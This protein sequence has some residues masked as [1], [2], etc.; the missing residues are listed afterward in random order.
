MHDEAAVRA[1]FRRQAGWCRNLGSP[2][3]ALVCD[4]AA[5]R[6]DRSTVLGRRILDWPAEP[7]PAVDVLTLRLAGG[8]HALARR[9]H[10]QLASCYPPSPTPDADTFWRAMQAALDNPA[11][12]PWLDSVPQTNEV[13]RSAA[14]MAG[15]LV[16]A[17]ETRLPV[18][19]Y[20]LGASAGLNLSPDRYDIRLGGVQTGMPGSAVVLR[21]DWSGA[22]PPMAAVRVVRR[23]GVDLSPMRVGDPADQE[24]L[25]AYVWADQA[26]RMARLEGA[27]AIAA[28]DPPA[29][30][31]GDAADWTEANIQPAP[32]PG[33]VRVLM[34]SV[35][36]TY[37]PAA[38][39][40]RI[41][42]HMAAAG[43]RATA[44][45]P[46]AWL[47]FEPPPG[48]AEAP[49][50]RLQCWPDGHERVLA[51]G[52]PHGSWIRWVQRHPV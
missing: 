35:A 47:Q 6:L 33:L 29:L 3:T 30:D 15:L 19:L 1:A 2:L 37:F 46:L 51:T 22:P 52:S 13:A 27:L 42:G 23:H 11:L 36:Y 40:A 50:L 34:H 25:R 8:L 24:R 28:A 14:L 12:A 26:A 10:P 44:E 20:E 18:A 7:G 39:Q 21:P 38:T 5:E 41:A 4:L 16:I 32:E 48:H 49:T 9:G 43:R 45:A 17:S 31:K